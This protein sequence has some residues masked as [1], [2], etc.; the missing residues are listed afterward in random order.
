ME[1]EKQ[2]TA[3]HGHKSARVARGREGRWEGPDYPSGLLQ[4]RG[5]E[6]RKE[7]RRKEGR[8]TKAARENKGR[9]K[10]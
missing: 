1:T 8:E 10:E 5:K 9:I 2:L 3:L 6:G 7:K 4:R